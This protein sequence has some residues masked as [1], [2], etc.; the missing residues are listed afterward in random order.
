MSKNPLRLRG[1]EA[2]IER[3]YKNIYELNTLVTSYLND[4]E[5]S[6]TLKDHLPDGTMVYGHGVTRAPEEMAVRIGEIIHNLRSALDHL[7]F[8][9]VTVLEHLVATTVIGTHHAA[10]QTDNCPRGTTV[11]LPAGL[12]INVANASHAD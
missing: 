6:M 1:S 4:T 10:A 3:A 2:K 11:V 5:Y 12:A 8:A 9:L 7:F